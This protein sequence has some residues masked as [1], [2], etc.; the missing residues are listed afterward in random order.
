M[1]RVNLAHSKILDYPHFQV[2]TFQI[3]QELVSR[4]YTLRMTQ[5]SSALDLSVE[6]VSFEHRPSACSDTLHFVRIQLCSFKR[7]RILFE[8]QQQTIRNYSLVRRQRHCGYTSSRLFFFSLLLARFYTRFVVVRLR[9][10]T[11]AEENERK[12]VEKQQLFVI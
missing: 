2:S 6:P 8:C 12:S 1:L 10:D 5:F 3:S 7:F 4:M 9:M 11:M